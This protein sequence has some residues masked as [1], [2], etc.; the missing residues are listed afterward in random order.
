[1]CQCENLQEDI[2]KEK[3][4]A[5]ASE[6]AL[7]KEAERVRRLEQRLDQLERKD[8]HDKEKQQGCCCLQ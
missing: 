4:A 6:A 3:A 2:E 8:A 1:M 7:R 5:T